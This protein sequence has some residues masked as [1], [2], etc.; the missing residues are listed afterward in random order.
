M[1]P[2]P[3]LAVAGGHDVRLYGVLGGVGR[4]PGGHHALVERAGRTV[5]V[6][7]TDAED[8]GAFLPHRVVAGHVRPGAVVEGRQAAGL[9]VATPDRPVVATVALDDG[10][11]VPVVHGRVVGVEPGIRSEEHT[12]ELQS[13]MYLVCRLLL[14]K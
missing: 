12:S 14:E 11:R 4:V 6:V 5:A 1:A 3:L 10:G 8:D 9:R 7:T 2:T 13:P